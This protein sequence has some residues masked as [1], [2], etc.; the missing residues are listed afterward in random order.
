M[1]QR[2]RMQKAQ[3]EA[4]R[5]GIAFHIGRARQ[6]GDRMKAN[7]QAAD[8]VFA[9]ENGVT[10]QVAVLRD[11]ARTAMEEARYNVMKARSIANTVPSIKRVVG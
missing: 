11:R 10:E 8:A 3:A 6:E 2:H 4:R 5:A 7:I 1:K 9:R